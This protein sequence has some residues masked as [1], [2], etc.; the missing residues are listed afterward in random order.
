MMLSN[1]QI[2]RRSRVESIE[3]FMDAGAELS[4]DIAKTAA[5][6]DV[7]KSQVSPML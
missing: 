2:S 7:L 3:R 5:R 1:N 6:S 4:G